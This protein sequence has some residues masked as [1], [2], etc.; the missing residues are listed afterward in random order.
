MFNL[1]I[2]MTS[3][4]RTWAVVLGLGF[5][6][7]TGGYAAE[8]KAGPVK[9]GTKVD[10]LKAKLGEPEKIV[11][12]EGSGVRVEKWFYPDHVVVVVQEG[13]VLDSFVEQP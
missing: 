10:E 2:P 1:Q 8:L 13:F 4:I 6:I 11:A 5:A 7:A 9:T 12:S 3:Q